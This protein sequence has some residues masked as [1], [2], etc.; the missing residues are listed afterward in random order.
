MDEIPVNVALLK[1]VWT[2]NPTTDAP[3][4]SSEDPAKETTPV[5]AIG[6]DQF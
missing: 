2:G 4:K 6:P 5:D 1:R 3:E